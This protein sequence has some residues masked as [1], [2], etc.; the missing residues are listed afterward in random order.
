MKMIH[1]AESRV[2][3]EKGLKRFLLHDSPYFR[4]LN[5][6]LQAGQIFPVHRHPADGQVSIQVIEGSGQFLGENETALPAVAG[7]ILVSDIN[8]PHGVKADTDMRILV[9]IAPPF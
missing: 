2:F 7:D 9:T 6:N 4:I 5:F 3:E 8:E 1:L